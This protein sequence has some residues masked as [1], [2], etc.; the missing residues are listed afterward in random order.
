MPLSN[1]ERK[2]VTARLWLLWEEAQ[3]WQS[4]G[5]PGG[6]FHARLR[7]C[8]GL[9]T[10]TG[11]FHNP[12]QKEHGVQFRFTWPGRTGDVFVDLVVGF[13]PDGDNHYDPNRGVRIVTPTRKD[14]AEGIIGWR[15]YA[16]FASADKP[17]VSFCQQEIEWACR[18]KNVN[19]FF[20]YQRPVEAN[21]P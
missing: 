2:K 7:K 16:D 10:A 13:A 21:Q 8:R 4:A 12:G 1:E 11:L 18:H 19:K 3:Q 5:F 15:Q 17:L 9:A 14:W 6:S 20:R